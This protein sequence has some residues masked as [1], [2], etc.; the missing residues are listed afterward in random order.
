MLIVFAGI[1]NSLE[2]E[3]AN[4]NLNKENQHLGSNLF[5]S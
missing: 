3:R 2:F 5:F 4:N 1:Q